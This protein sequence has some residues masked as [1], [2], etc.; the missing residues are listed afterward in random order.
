MKA[1]DDLKKIGKKFGLTVADMERI[2]RFHEQAK[3]VTVGQKLIVYRAM[4]ASE[5]QKAMCKLTPGGAEAKAS[6]RRTTTT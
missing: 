4:S 1:G 5:K 6:P 3:P 2:N